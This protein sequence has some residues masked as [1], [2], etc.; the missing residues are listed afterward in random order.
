MASA[1]ATLVM[2]PGETMVGRF[3]GVWLKI[4]DVQGTLGADD[5]NPAVI[6]KRRGITRGDARH[7]LRGTGR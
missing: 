5:V 1:S 6:C 7:G 2:V 3:G 4:G